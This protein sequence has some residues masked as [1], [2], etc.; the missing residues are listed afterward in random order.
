MKT[1]HLLRN[2]SKISS[3]PV[4]SLRGMWMT[5]VF[6]MSVLPTFP[7]SSNATFSQ[8]SGFGVT[9][10]AS[11]IGQTTAKYGRAHVHA[12]RFRDPASGEA[13]AT[14]GTY[15]QNGFGLSA[16]AVLALLLASKLQAVTDSH[17]STLYKLKWKQSVT[18]RGQLLFRLAASGRRISESVFIGYP[19]PRAHD[20]KSESGADRY[21]MA[22]KQGKPLAFVVRAAGWVSPTA[23]DG[24]R[25]NR[26]PR[27]HDTGIPLSQQVALGMTSNG[28]SSGMERGDRLNPDF[29]RWLMG[30]P[31]AWE[32]CAPTETQLL[33]RKRRRSSAR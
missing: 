23:T 31:D 7:A 22:R 18:P 16:H 24:N 19:T 30:I 2:G 11:P 14:S 28:C 15:G 13:S 5:E 32:D 6:A 3:M 26:P 9:P 25:G 27:L 8:V 1:V 33:R 17:G 29:S 20:W 12:S 21:R 10:Y 4:L